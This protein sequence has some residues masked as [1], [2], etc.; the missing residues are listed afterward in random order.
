MA[1]QS[2]QPVPDSPSQTW[3]DNEVAYIITDAERA[4]FLKLGTDA[5]RAQFIEQFWLRRDPTPDTIENEFKEEHYRR[6][7]Y[8]NARFGSRTGIPGW[9]TDRGRIYI[10]FGPP[11]AI[12]SHPLTE[13][14]RYRYIDGIGNDVTMEFVDPDGSGEFHM[15]RDP[16]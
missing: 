14:W 1:W 13:D 4:A 9:K 5:E 3:L 11:D 10:K 2:P 7:G 16:H 15:S 6:M 12:D 8:A